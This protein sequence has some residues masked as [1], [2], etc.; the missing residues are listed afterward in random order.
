MG[1]AHDV[2]QTSIRFVLVPLPECWLVSLELDLPCH[3]FQCFPLLIDPAKVPIFGSIVSTSSLYD[4][5]SRAIKVSR[6]TL[7][8]HSPLGGSRIALSP[9]VGWES[10]LVLVGRS[11]HGGYIGHIQN[12]FFV[13]PHTLLFDCIP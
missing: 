13:D 5:H 10:S 6:L 8:I 4:H 1:L 11:P 12:R 9:V 7:F 3:S 2:N